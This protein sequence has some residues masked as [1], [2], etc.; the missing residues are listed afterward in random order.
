[1]SS[2]VINLST[3][4]QDFSLP[5][6]KFSVSARKVSPYLSM[7]DY[8]KLYYPYVDTARIDSVFGFVLQPSPFYGGRPYNPKRVLTNMHLAQLGELGVNLSIN[9]T[10]HYF[11]DDLYEASLAFLER[12]HAQ[13]NSITCT[14]NLLAKR[15]KRDFPRYLVRASVLKKLHTWERIETAL[16]VY[17]QVVLPMEKNDD[18]EL[19]ES[20]PWKERIMLFANATCGYA[21][22]DRTCWLGVSQKNQG[23]KETADCTKT[24][25]ERQAFGKVFFDAGKFYRMGYRHFKLIPAFASPQT[26]E[27]AR[28]FSARQ[29]AAALLQRYL[30]KSSFYLCSFQKSGRTWLRYLLANY[31]NLQF[32][33]GL[34]IDFR[35]F[36]QLIPHDILD[37]EKGVGVY[38]YYDDQRFPLILAS[39]DVYT[40]EKF[41]DKKIIF[42][43][44]SAFDTVVSRYFQHAHVF[45]PDRSWKGSLKDF[46]RAPEG[47]PAYCTH[48][49]SWSE[50]LVNNNAAHTLSY[51]A[52]HRDI[53]ATVRGVL[54]F[55]DIPVDEANLAQAV[56]LSSFDAMKEMETKTKVPG[57]NFNFTS[58][59]ADSARVRKGKVG[60]YRDDLDADDIAH[61][62]DYCDAN[63]SSHSKKLL[64]PSDFR[65]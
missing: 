3:H 64:L 9:L 27:V 54:E 46:I 15:I 65:S 31:L 52:M 19:L 55:M 23:R 16:E 1:M 22:P 57:V 12:Y 48:L 5:G 58:G 7:D 34:P 53:S 62:R 26:E 50:F 4:L 41:V 25:A 32:Q 11:A 17:D 8:L 33:L 28:H 61:I 63:L 29:P 13:G 45:T 38:N 30:H 2:N 39:H 47:I 56:A 10:N 18:D 6:A 36:F 44:R 40:T 35:T 49:N 51:E 14:S 60:G 42:L 37:E 20:L 59:D 43:V 24:P 21:C